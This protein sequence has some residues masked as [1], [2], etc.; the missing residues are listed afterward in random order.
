MLVEQQVNYK[1]ISNQIITA[2]VL[3]AGISDIS[4]SYGA[5]TLK[6]KILGLTIGVIVNG[7]TLV[8]EYFG[9]LNEKFALNEVLDECADAFSDKIIFLNANISYSK[10]KLIKELNSA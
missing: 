6:G 10:K 8:L 7:I 2:S 9:Y 4:I 1:K 3:L 5:F